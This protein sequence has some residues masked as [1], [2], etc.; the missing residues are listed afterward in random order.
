MLRVPATLSLLLI[1]TACSP[2]PPDPERVAG[3]I[4]QWTAI[5][6]RATGEDAGNERPWGRLYQFRLNEDGSAIVYNAKDPIPR[7]PIRTDYRVTEDGVIEFLVFGSTIYQS[8]RIAN[9]G[10]ELELDN[11][12]LYDEDDR[13][14]AVRYRYRR[15]PSSS[16]PAIG[17]WRWGNACTRHTDRSM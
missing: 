5:N 4:G 8:W 12:H 17:P 14:R 6:P 15:M 10:N 16:R 13:L 1:S 3:L 9:R 11:L 2:T 7:F